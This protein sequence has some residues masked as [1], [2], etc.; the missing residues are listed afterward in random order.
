MFVTKSFIVI[1]L[2]YYL[3]VEFFVVVLVNFVFLFNSAS[4]KMNNWEL[5][6]I[7]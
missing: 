4:Y 6:L 1:N 3:N 5:I 2:V 7:F